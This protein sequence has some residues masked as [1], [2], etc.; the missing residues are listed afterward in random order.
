M[1]LQT[2]KLQPNY[3]LTHM[4]FKYKQL[5]HVTSI[6]GFAIGNQNPYWFIYKDIQCGFKNLHLHQLLRSGFRDRGPL[7]NISDLPFD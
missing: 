2:L 3:F 4:M 7:L 1:L 6:H 5:H